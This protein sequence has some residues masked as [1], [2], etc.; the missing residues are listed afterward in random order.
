MSYTDQTEVEAFL[1]R[2]LSAAE[3]AFL[4]YLIS[5][6]QISID[7]EL[8]GSYGT[9]SESSKFYDGGFQI[10]PIDPAYEITAVEVVDTDV[11]N[12][13]LDE[14]VI[15]EDLELFPLNKETKTYMV[16]RYG[17]FAC[18]IGKIKVTGRF[19]LGS[20]VP[21]HITYLATYIVANTL[22]GAITAGVKE[23]QIEGYSRKY[24]SFNFDNDPEVA[25]ILDQEKEILL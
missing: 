12:T 25:R 15:G 22:A 24:T 20:S 5:S 19:S 10:L 8:G 3:I 1:G 14:Y 13:V 9:V 11:S 21:S 6:A 18:G 16:K 2:D 7:S 23:E 17:Y 4:P